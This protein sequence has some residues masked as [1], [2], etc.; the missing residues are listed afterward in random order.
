MIVRVAWIVL[1]ITVLLSLAVRI[2]LK[3]MPLERDEGEYAYAGQ[4][5][6]QGVPPYK[7][8]YNMKLPGTY[9]A[10]AAIMAVLGQTPSGI[11]LGVAAVNMA[12]IVLVFFIGRRLLDSV[13][14]AVAALCFALLS[15]S[16]ALIGVAGHATHFVTLFALGGVLLLMRALE[17][18]RAIILFLSGLMFG[19]ALL[20]K[21]PGATFGL[22]ALVYVVWRNF[23]DGKFDWRSIF[24]QAGPIGTG[25]VLPL[26]VTCLWLAAAGVFKAFLFW[27][28]GYA[29]EYVSA[30]PWSQLHANLH[31]IDDFTFLPTSPFWLLAGIGALMMWWDERLQGRHF[32]I[33]SLIVASIAATAA[34]LYFRPHYFITLAPVL[35]LL[36]GFAVSCALQQLLRER[37]VELLTALGTQAVFAV[38][39]LT[40]FVANG[41]AWFSDSPQDVSRDI[42]GSTV[43]SESVNIADFI[44]ENSSKDSRLAVIGSE[45][46][47]YFYSHRRSATG[48]IYMYGL[49]G[50]HPFARQMQEEMIREVEAA[51]PEWIVNVDYRYSWLQEEN[52]DERIFNWWRDYWK[53]HYELVRTVNI[54]PRPNPRTLED[55]SSVEPTKPVG[56][57]LILRR[58][59]AESSPAKAS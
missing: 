7:L 19:F 40:A 33:V 32:F 16:T 49:M 27:C 52:S 2:R 46:Q 47:L 5:L 53:A 21:Q 44:R 6:L 35:A 45:P 43:F 1:A 51:R 17:G 41:S 9:I 26:L 28:I 15:T 42:N 25:F 39:L 30:L 29:N 57:F 58:K 10:Y 50:A 48:H 4:L 24:K 36:C 31:S 22:F 55:D 8:A 23:N 3:D 37:S 38:A 56:R 59:S 20:M 34:G 12:S 11:H 13:A 18:N 14:G 54:M